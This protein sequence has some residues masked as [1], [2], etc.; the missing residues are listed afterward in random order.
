MSTAGWMVGC[1]EGIRK[2]G[3]ETLARLSAAQTAP[4]RESLKLQSSNDVAHVYVGCASLRCETPPFVF[5]RVNLAL[6]RIIVVISRRWLSEIEK[7]DVSE[8]RVFGK[9]VRRAYRARPSHA[10][11][12]VLV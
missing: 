6:S 1:R 12:V 11:N 5:G 4:A 9:I 7:D 8:I 2:E 10:L 3:G